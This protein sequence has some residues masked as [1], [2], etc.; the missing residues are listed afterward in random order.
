M[1]MGDVGCFLRQRDDLKQPTCLS[2][3][4]ATGIHLKM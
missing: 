4:T 2:Q 1:G 3:S